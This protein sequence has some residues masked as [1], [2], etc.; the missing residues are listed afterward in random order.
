MKKYPSIDDFRQLVKQVRSNH[1]FKGKD[2][3]DNPIYENTSSYPVLTFKGTVKLHGSNCSVVKYKNGTI[4]YQSRERVLSLDDDN[5][6]FMNEMIRFD[7]SYIFDRIEFNDYCVIFGEWCGSNIQKGTAINGLPKM[8][9]IFGIKAD[10]KWLDIPNDIQRE[11]VYNINSF[12]TF[13]IEIDFNKPELSFDRIIE[14]TNRVENKCPVGESFGKIGIGEGIVFVCDSNKK[15]RFKSKGEKFSVKRHKEPKNIDPEKLNSVNEF[16]EYAVT[17]N[18]F[19]QGLSF[20][21]EN[22]IEIDIKNIGKFLQWVIKD[23]YKEELDVIVN[24]NIDQKMLNKQ[25]N[26]VARTWFIKNY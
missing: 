26:N 10:G 12:E 11:N 24:N 15:Y 4:E 16:I 19:K 13:S 17:E 20:L 7:F 23:V 9:V 8:F 22:N 21:I 1:D 2:E 5:S 18:R 14:L 3:F 25:I 6:G